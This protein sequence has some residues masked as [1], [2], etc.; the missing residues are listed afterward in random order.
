MKAWCVLILALFAAPVRADCV[1]LL[2]GLGRSDTSM[3]ILQYQLHKAGYA[4]V[5]V[6]YPSTDARVEDL[7][8]LTL[9][10]AIEACGNRKIH[11]VTHSMGGILVRVWLRQNS[12]DA[13]G[14]VVM[15]GPP[16][17]GSEI[18]DNLGDVAGFEWINGPAG[19][20]LGT[21]PDSL[22]NR[23]GPVQFELGVIAGN[24]SLNPFYSGLIDGDDDGKVSV[25]RTKVAGMTDHLTL[26]VSH[27]FMMMNGDAIEQVIAFLDSG[28]F[29]RD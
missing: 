14:R 7:A 23:L 27:T 20:Q 26:P 21:G 19:R 24:L 22:P 29:I 13:L 16:N 9:P 8:R 17:Q 4:T 5:N 15:L 12:L 11:F 2:H 25:E 3:E 10:P 1:V 28:A 6:E 18:V